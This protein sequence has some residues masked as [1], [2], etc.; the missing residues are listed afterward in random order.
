MFSGVF[1]QE[2]KTLNAAYAIELFERHDSSILFAGPLCA[3]INPKA[4]SAEG[5]AFLTDSGETY[6]LPRLTITSSGYFTPFEHKE[7][8]RL[9][10]ACELC[11]EMFPVTESNI[12]TCP[13]CGISYY[14]DIKSFLEDKC[15][16][17]QPPPFH[18][19]YGIPNWPP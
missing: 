11:F 5:A 9:Y 7:W 19:L 4:I 18:V 14:E 3:Q 2:I 13:L 15:V 1:S 10:I 12:G 8:S 6:K 16:F 17:V